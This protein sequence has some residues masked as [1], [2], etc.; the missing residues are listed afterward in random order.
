MSALAESS[1]DANQGMR[2]TAKITRAKTRTAS[3]NREILMGKRP[4]GLQTEGNQ[5]RKLVR[6]RTH[7]RE[8]QQVKSTGTHSLQCR[9][10]NLEQSE[11]KN[12]NEALLNRIGIPRSNGKIEG[13]TNLGIKTMSP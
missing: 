2:A 9:K 10:Q 8:N 11:S 3:A 13:D 6:D 4:A 12:K 7:A 5:A 1:G